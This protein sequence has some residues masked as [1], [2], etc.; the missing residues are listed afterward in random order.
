MEIIKIGNEV[1]KRIAIPVSGY[2]AIKSTAKKMEKYIR[3]TPNALGLAAPQIGISSRFFVALIP[4]LCLC[5]NPSYTP[6]GN[7][8]VIVKEG[9]LSCPG[10]S[11]EVE[12]WAV[13]DAAF[14]DGK[15]VRNR[16]LKGMNAVVYQH[17]HDHLDGIL[18]VELIKEI[19]ADEPQLKE[20]RCTRNDP[21]S[22]PKCL[23]HSDLTSR[24]GHYI[25]GL[26][27]SD[28]LAQM[29]KRF[30]DDSS[31]TIHLKGVKNG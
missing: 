8:K 15:K 16:R 12:R 13:I 10:E 5:I 17:E 29:K 3:K 23:G 18:F 7:E 26:D 21:Y 31:F 20:Y 14:F 11:G 6:V 22:D 25:E 28:A 30:P 19:V 24:Q 27:E 9:C 1:L 2:P 4:D